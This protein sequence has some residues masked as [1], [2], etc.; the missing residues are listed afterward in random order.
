MHGGAGSTTHFCFVVHWAQLQRPASSRRAFKLHCSA[1]SASGDCPTC[2]MP[3]HVLRLVLARACRRIA[4]QDEAQVFITEGLLTTLMCAPRSVYSWDVVVTR[5][6]GKL[7]F[8]RRDGSAGEL[9]TTAETAPEVRQ[10]C[11]EGWTRGAPARLP[12]TWL[13]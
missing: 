2:N 8:D 10:R 1:S 11:P 9:L 6:G 4:A 5:A 7:F 3:V 13:A 12:R